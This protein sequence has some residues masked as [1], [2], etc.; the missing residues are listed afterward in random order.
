MTLRFAGTHRVAW[1]AVAAAIIDDGRRWYLAGGTGLALYLAHRDSEDLDL[2]LHDSFDAEQLADNLTASNQTFVATDVTYN[3]VNG[4][5]HG[6]KVQFLGIPNQRLL[7]APTV[8]EGIRVASLE[9]I[10]AMKIQAIHGRAKLRDYYDLMTLDQRQIIPINQAISA[11]ITRFQ[12]RNP[13][14]NVWQ[15]I[16]CL[17]YL[18]DV[19]PDPL[20]GVTITLTQDR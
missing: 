9:D 1:D 18:D 2:F 6:T 20:T 8:I 3:T 14:T 17:G 7:Q 5:I 15:I 10:A 19:D 16:Q 11:Y 4:Y 13:E 12:P